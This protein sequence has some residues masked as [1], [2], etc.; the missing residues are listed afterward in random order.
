[1]R[2]TVFLQ[3]D[4]WVR[5]RGYSKRPSRG[6][7]ELT[8]F[9]FTHQI[10]VEGRY[11]LGFLRYFCCDEKTL[12]GYRGRWKMFDGRSSAEISVGWGGGEGGD[13]SVDSRTPH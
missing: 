1:M 6:I 4:A 11:G 3:R 10:S 13:V 2:I 5:G 9:I 7:Y 8:G 12:G